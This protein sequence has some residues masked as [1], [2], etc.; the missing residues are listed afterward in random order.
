M[1]QLRLF[2]LAPEALAISAYY[3]GPRGWTLSIR[4]RR[5]GESWADGYVEHYELL[6]TAEMADVIDRACASA[7]GL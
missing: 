7:L 1:D 2:R 3:E 6:S 4:C 5:Q